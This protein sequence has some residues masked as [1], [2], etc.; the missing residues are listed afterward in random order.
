MVK[1]IF[2]IL[3]SFLAF[4]A[5]YSQDSREMYKINPGQSID[6]VIKGEIRLMYPEFKAGY[7]LFRNGNF[8]ASK[9]NYN[10]LH[11]ELQFINGADTLALDGGEDIRHVIIEK[12]TFYYR[13]KQWLRQMA[14]TGKVRMAE[15]KFLEFVNRE[16]IGAFGQVNSGSSIDAVEN[17]VTISNI[18]KKLETNQIITFAMNFNYYFSDKYDNYKLANRKNIANMFGNS[19]RG[20]DK[21][22]ES[23][24][25]NYHSS[26]DMNKVF[27]YINSNLK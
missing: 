2:L 6:D 8:G 23:E 12:D 24:K 26:T 11:Q 17:L 15:L 18:T 19:C 20:L 9:M 5:G 16:K 7:V 25:I 27:E 4:G 13:D 21:F 1:T 10:F 14:S 3:I 22:L